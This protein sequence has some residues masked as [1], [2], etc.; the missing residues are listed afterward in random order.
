MAFMSQT[1]NFIKIL[2]YKTHL[3][4]GNLVELTANYAVAIEDCS[5]SQEKWQK[6]IQLEFREK[7]LLSCQCCCCTI[8]E[9]KAIVT[10]V[11]V[12]PP[13]LNCSK[14]KTGEISKKLEKHLP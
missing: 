4:L 10:N 8:Q 11:G 14:K 2:G 13:F 7:L 5:V 9:F 3:K 6:E 1:Q 12:R